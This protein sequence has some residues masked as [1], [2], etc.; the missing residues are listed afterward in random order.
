MICPPP[1]KVF[2]EQFLPVVGLFLRP[3]FS[4]LLV[5]SSLSPCRRVV[6]AFPSCSLFLSSFL[7][8]LSSVALVHSHRLRL[9]A[10]FLRFQSR[11]APVRCLFRGLWCLLCFTRRTFPPSDLRCVF[12]I[13]IQIQPSAVNSAWCVCFFVFG[14]A[15]EACGRRCAWLRWCLVLVEW[16]GYVRRMVPGLD[17]SSNIM[18]VQGN[19]RAHL[20]GSVLLKNLLKIVGEEIC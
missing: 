9:D 3:C 11:C 4:N 17:V 7:F 1:K 20:V 8:P 6:L 14:G 10:S 12:G 15:R 19:G 13:S 5:R 16:D 18:C 2:R